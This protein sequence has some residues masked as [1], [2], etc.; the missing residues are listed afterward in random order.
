MATATLDRKELR[1]ALELLKKVMPRRA[2]APCLNMVLIEP[3][4]GGARVTGTDL[5]QRLTLDITGHLDAPMLIGPAKELTALVQAAGSEVA[6]ETEGDAA[7]VVGSGKCDAI[8]PEEYPIGMP[9]GTCVADT[10]GLL[11]AIKATAWSVADK[12]EMR[13]ALQTL[14]LQG[15]EGKM[16]AASAN[17][18]C[19]SVARTDIPYAGPDMLV[20]GA[21]LPILQTLLAKGLAT[22]Y[23][24]APD[25]GGDF[26]KRCGQDTAP[27]HLTLDGEGWQYQVRLFDGKF[28]NWRQVVPKEPGDPAILDRAAVLDVA[29][30]AAQATKGKSGD[31]AALLVHWGEGLHVTTGGGFFAV[32]PY[33]G[34]AQPDTAVNPNYLAGMAEHMPDANLTCWQHDGQSPFVFTAKDTTMM[35]MPISIPKKKG[36][37]DG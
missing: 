12:R 15:D 20:P 26:N 17:G 24:H 33:T 37:D 29:T 18:V 3:T 16:V 34:E 28:P 8:D 31:G 14:L 36:E 25:K 30:R 23:L 19:L 6:I 21:N 27:W 10:R 4:A 2:S 9:P 7:F 13:L 35:I 11:A 22:M 5:E 1:T 32:L